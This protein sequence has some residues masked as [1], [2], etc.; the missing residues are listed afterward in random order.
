M[1][2]QLKLVFGEHVKKQI[3]NYH[4]APKTE[5]NTDGAQIKVVP[6]SEGCIKGDLQGREYRHIHVSSRRLG[7]LHR[8]ISLQAKIQKT[9]RYAPFSSGGIIVIFFP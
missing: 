9:S 6:E 4:E 1:R 3:V 5:S 2:T 7:R 8:I